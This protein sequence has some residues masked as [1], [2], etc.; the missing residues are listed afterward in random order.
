MAAD[1]STC[2]GLEDD[3]FRP[4]RPRACWADEHHVRVVE[5]RLEVDDS[6]LRDADAAARAACLRVALEDVDALDH[7]LVLVGNR[8]QDLAGLALVLARRHDHRVA[9][10]KVEPAALRCF[11][12]SKHFYLN[13][14]FLSGLKSRWLGADFSPK[15]AWCQ[16]AG[17]PGQLHVG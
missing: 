11:F 15:W 3:V 13:S 4:R 9:G 12:V 14:P 6:T 1:E 5:R 2:A 10:S 17:S 8:A 7:D 16:L